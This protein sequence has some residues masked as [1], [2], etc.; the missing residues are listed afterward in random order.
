MKVMVTGGAGYIG[1]HV[2]RALEEAGHEVVRFD[3]L[4]TGRIELAAGRP[5]VRA[6]LLDAAA[7][8][9]ALRGCDAVAHLAGSALV[10]ESVA[11]PTEY[12]RNNLVAGL[13]LVEEMVAQGITSMVFA[14][15]CAVYG[16]PERVPI[17]EDAPKAPISPYGQSK[18]AFERLLADARAAHGL[19]SV[20]L[21]FF[22]AAG[23]HERGD[24]GEMH[25]PETHIIPLV[26]Q[27]IAGRRER[28]ML[29]GDDFPTKDGT[30]VRDYVDVRDLARAHL[31]V[32]QAQS[33]GRELPPALNLGHGI[34]FSN[35]EI[36][37]ACEDVTG[38][39]APVA[40]GPRREGDPPE[41]VAQA[42][43]ARTAL[44]WTPVHDLRAMVETAWRFMQGH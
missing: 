36:I 5:L 16:I 8:R 18:L 31:M 11:R 43:L 17:A 37:A 14:S 29:N 24:I 21:R 35:R 2:A 25:D 39:R 33:E 3:R 44:S 1:S 34:G 41:L 19:R 26:L 4:S 42:G 7:V 30:C 38:K 20:A 6:S 22:N 10:G 12:W 13:I 9:D 27:A 23:A 40:V 28:F 15:S 32:L